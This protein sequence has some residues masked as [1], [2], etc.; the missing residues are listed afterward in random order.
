MFC[1]AGA[2]AKALAV[3]YEDTLDSL[4]VKLDRAEQSCRDYQ[5]LTEHQ[6]SELSAAHEHEN[7]LEPP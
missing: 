1:P 6:R 2:D 7:Q 5:K 4:R 3:S